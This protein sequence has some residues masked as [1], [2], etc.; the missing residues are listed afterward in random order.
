MKPTPV[1]P[2]GSAWLVVF[3]SLALLVGCQRNS[4]PAQSLDAGIATV[5][6]RP[7]PVWKLEAELE[8]TT[9]H[10]HPPD[11]RQAVASLIDREQLVARALRLG[12]D[13]E[14]EV[15]RAWEMALIAKLK[16]RELEPALQAVSRL[17]ADSRSATPTPERQLE[18]PEQIRLAMLR[19]EANPK[20]SPAKH[21]TI[22]RRLEEA[23]TRAT[24]LPADTVGFGALAFEY[25]DDDST[26]SR[27]GDLGW[28]ETDPSKYHL[29]PQVL[30]A[31][32]ALRI[33]GEI[34]PVVRGHDAFYLVR[35]LARKPADTRPATAADAALVAHRQQLERRKVIEQSFVEETRRTI[36]VTVNTTLVE[37]WIAQR[38]TAEHASFHE[39]RPR[40]ADRPLSPVND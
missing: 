11:P 13:R 34:S 22:Q 30:T 27:G 23:R 20:A 28:L 1:L 24:T 31:G 32:L 3:T 26:R 19:L 33:P 40:S 16:E 36:P 18:E 14:P 9:R 4:Q 37:E 7:V 35:L 38:Q 29:D 21:Q 10:G 2:S 39:E 15:H 5:D 17:E 12:L 6:G 25:S 8:R